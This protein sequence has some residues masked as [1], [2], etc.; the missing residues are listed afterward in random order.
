M[1]SPST[2][3]KGVS[4]E[5]D[6]P[7]WLSPMLVK[8][9][10]QGMRTNTFASVFIGV[11]ALLT[12]FLFMTFLSGGGA[13][14][15]DRISSFIL[16]FF[17]LVALIIQPLRGLSAV[18]NEVKE[19]TIDLMQLTRLNSWRIVSGKW[20]SLV[21]QTGLVLTTMIPYLVMRYYFSGMQ[22]LAELSLL[23]AV[24][25]LSVGFTGLTVGLS[26]TQSAAVRGLV[27]L[28]AMPLGFAV[29]A[30]FIFTT[31]LHRGLL[32]DFDFSSARDFAFP[33]LVLGAALYGC[34]YF[35]ELGTTQISSLSENRSTKK[36]L[37][38]FALILVIQF[39]FLLFAD[40]VDQV[41]AVLLSVCVLAALG[42]DCL[43][44]RAQLTRKVS[45]PFHKKGP[46]GRLAGVFLLPGWHTGAL[47]LTVVALEIYFFSLFTQPS[48]DWDEMSFL[49][50][51][52]LYSLLAPLP[53]L[54]LFRRKVKNRLPIYIS[55]Q[56][57][58]GILF[59]LTM[60]IDTRS[61][62]DEVI[63]VIPW[64]FF[65][66]FEYSYQKSADASSFIA[67]H[68]GYLVTGLLLSALPVLFTFRRQSRELSQ[69]E[70]GL[71]PDEPTDV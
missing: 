53:V 65:G 24:F 1:S 31:D 34:Y 67:W 30:G 17:A 3:P 54:Y 28:A 39:A 46:L 44:E 22:P 57:V 5:S 8:E 59:T 63:A 15:G 55:A 56:V 29:I 68:W 61:R 49:P 6:F 43:S 11:Q 14:T 38:G 35:L 51:G 50:S 12:L 20:S 71:A 62:L 47:F 26:A 37:I 70:T 66:L 42:F 2:E 33:G 16:G 52:V 60:N 13:L 7:D 58:L 23:F 36:R 64:G 19:Q 48:S 4:G 18:S 45:E 21:I 10:R 25:V 69:A 27:V 40:K 32:R 41:G 9:L